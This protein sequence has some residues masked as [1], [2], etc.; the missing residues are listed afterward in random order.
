MDHLTLTYFSRIRYG[1]GEGGDVTEDSPL[2]DDIGSPRVN[3][4]LA[5]E[6]ASLDAGGCVLRLA[7]L[8]ALERG[9]HNYW[10]TVNKPIPSSPDGIVNQ[11]HY[12]DAAGACFAALQ[13]VPNKT[14]RRVFLISDGNPQTRLEISKSALQAA[15]YKDAQLPRFDS[16]AKVNGNV[17]KGAASNAALQW[18]PRYP[19]FDAFMKSMA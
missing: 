1:P 2:A 9:A 5:A 12:E 6:Q 19:S 16:A 17:F 14:Q 7:G 4:L 10:M 11:V 13:T 15:V 3:R 18:K 8:Y